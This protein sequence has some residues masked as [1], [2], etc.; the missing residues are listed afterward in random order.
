MRQESAH[1]SGRELIQQVFAFKGTITLAVGERGSAIQI[2][3]IKDLFTRLFDLWSLNGKVIPLEGEKRPTDADLCKLAREQL[4]PKSDWTLLDDP[5]PMQSCLL[6]KKWTPC[7]DP[8]VGFMLMY[9]GQSLVENPVCIQ[10]ENQAF[11]T[12]LL[13]VQV[14]GATPSKK[15]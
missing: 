13:A 11:V 6:D 8:P 10:K 4:P 15:V 5:L 1:N 14:E 3:L 12:L 2:P 7:G 9:S